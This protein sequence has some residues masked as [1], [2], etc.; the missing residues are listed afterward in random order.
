LDVLR[1]RGILLSL[2]LASATVG[3]LAG[4]TIASAHQASP[5]GLLVGAL[6]A[7]PALSSAASGLL[8][9]NINLGSDG[10]LTI[11]VTGSDHRDTRNIGERLDSVIVATINPH[12]QQISAVSI[13]RD[14]GDMVLPDANDP[15]KGKVNSL[16]AHYKKITGNRSAALEKFRQA[17]AKTLQ[18]EIDYVVYTRFAGFDQ[19]VDAVNG[20]PV[21]I[22]KEIDD[23]RVYD[24]G[25]GKPK[26]AKFLAGT[27]QLL[28]GTSAPKCYGMARPINFSKIPNCT[29]ALIYVR[30]RHGYVGTVSNSDWKR[31]ARQQ[32]FLFSAVARVIANGNGQALTNLQTSATSMTDNFYTTLPISDAGDLMA[33][34]NLFDGAQNVPLQS[35]VFKPNTY[36]F[37]VPGTRKYDLKLSAVRAL[38][39]SWFAPVS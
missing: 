1:I 10:R 32:Q 13:P 7:F 28:K 23:T 20:V 38:T 17:I 8:G 29:H 25:S 6:R 26:G 31:D 19:L 4:P 24:S 16:F 18:V 39:A 3:S 5:L 33:L 15:Y 21:N 22:P 12:T 30:S 37:H 34:F 9:N 2:A 36:A 35:A 27:N 11:L 14:T